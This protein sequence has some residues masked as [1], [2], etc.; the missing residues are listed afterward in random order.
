M[1]LRHI[2]PLV[3]M[4]LFTS[5][6]LMASDNP[7]A[8]QHG[9]AEVQFAVSGSSVDVIFT[10]PAHNLLGFEHKARTEEQKQ[11][12]LEI[13]DWLGTT[14]LINTPENTCTISQATVD[15]EAMEEEVSHGDTH[16]HHEHADDHSQG[17]SDIEVTQTLTCP[18]I[19]AATELRS[20]LS[21]QFPGINQ[22][23]VAWVGPRGQGSVRLANGDHR[24]SLR[25]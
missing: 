23:D 8:H 5:T 3:G 20:N 12:I 17:H 11:L 25:P 2:Y 15:V 4:T 24:F 16:D 1:K 6:P 10:S 13:R 22:L 21:S 14:P 9:H 7:T 19:E 18:G